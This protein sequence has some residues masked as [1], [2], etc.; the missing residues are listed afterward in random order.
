MPVTT[1]LQSAV[2]HIRSG[3]V[4]LAKEPRLKTDP[5]PPAVDANA[6]F[7]WASP[8]LV[9]Y[10]D[11]RVVDPAVIAELKKA[12]AQGADP[13]AGPP[14]EDPPADAPQEMVNVDVQP[15]AADNVTEDPADEAEEDSDDD[16]EGAVWKIGGKKE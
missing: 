13:Q 4:D 5:N 8:I 14:K 2:K 12:V 3:K 9:S 10:N 16:E 7:F 1:A 6:P 15:P 11:D